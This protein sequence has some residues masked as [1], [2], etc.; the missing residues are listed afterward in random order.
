MGQENVKYCALLYRNQ[1]KKN[2]VRRRNQIGG[3][4]KTFQIFH[5]E[6]LIKK[7]PFGPIWIFKKIL[8]SIFALIPSPSEIPLYNV[9]Y[10]IYVCVLIVL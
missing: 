10:F 7:F 9:I 6:F 2:C 8:F 1:N 4:S 3:M 5:L